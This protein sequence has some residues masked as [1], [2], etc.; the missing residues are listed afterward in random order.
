MPKTKVNTIVKMRIFN[1]LSDNTKFLMRVLVFLYLTLSFL[2][3]N[4]NPGEWDLYTRF[5]LVLFFIIISEYH[6]IKN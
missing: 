2:E 1:R 4:I 3:W 6:K 5:F